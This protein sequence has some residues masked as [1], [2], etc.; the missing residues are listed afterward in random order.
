LFLA[1]STDPTTVAFGQVNASAQNNY[2][3]R[4]QVMVKFLF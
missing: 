1:P 4:T 3:R 2:A